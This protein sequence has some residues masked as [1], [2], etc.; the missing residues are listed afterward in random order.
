MENLKEEQEPA[1]ALHLVTVLLFQRHTNCIIHVPGRLVP[2]VI[3][4]LAGRMPTQDHARLVQYQHLVMQQLRLA[5]D[6]GTSGEADSPAELPGNDSSSKEEEG[7]GGEAP[8]NRDSQEQLQE[9]L[10]GLK[11][12]VRKPRVSNE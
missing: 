10:V 7:R 6:R 4:F 9:M 11:D 1:M 2:S 12:L 3:A 5:S 8:T